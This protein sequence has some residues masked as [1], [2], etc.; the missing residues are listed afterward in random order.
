MADLLDPLRLPGTGGSLSL[1]HPPPPSHT[2][3]LS[4][5]G[6]LTYC[7]RLKQSRGRKSAAFLGYLPHAW[8][9][10]L[11]ICWKYPPYVKKKMAGIFGGWI[12]IG[13]LVKY[14]PQSI[15][16]KIPTGVKNIFAFL[17][18]SLLTLPTKLPQRPFLLRPLIWTVACVK[19]R[20]SGQKEWTREK[21]GWGFH[22]IWCSQWPL[23]MG[24]CIRAFTTCLETSVSSMWKGEVVLYGFK[25][26]LQPENPDFDS[27]FTRE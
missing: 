23:S 12:V 7:A 24:L 11:T 8:P 3:L 2:S 4:H 26:H 16:Q 18:C 14:S 27:K 22:R 20:V 5:P 17:Y 19:S 1:A 21:Q 13:F 6:A 9:W 25:Q 15:P 10:S